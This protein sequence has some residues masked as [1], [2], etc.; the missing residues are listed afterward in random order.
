MRAG[1]VVPIDGQVASSSA[2]IDES[3]L[4]GEPIPVDAASGEAVSSGTINVGETFEMRGHRDGGRQHLRRNRSDGHRR[5]DRESAI[6]PHGG[7]LRPAAP[8]CDALHC[9]DSPGGLS[10]D[11][12]RALAVLVAATPCPLILAAPAAFIGRRRRKRR[13]AASWSKA[14]ARSR[15]LRAST[16]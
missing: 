6:H 3:V 4:T 14:A 10:G 9:R 12:I 8:A 11:P 2:L 5:A 1:E 13:V 16:R 7:S 15:R